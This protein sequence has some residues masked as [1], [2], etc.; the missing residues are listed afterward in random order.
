MNAPFA[1][2]L[3]GW[4]RTESKLV[5]NTADTDS[6]SSKAISAAVLDELQVPR[7]VPTGVVN[8]KSGRPLEKAVALSLR[9]DLPLHDA[10]RDWKVYEVPASISD[11]VQYSHLKKV[12]TLV[13]SNFELRITLGQDYLIKP[14]VTVA[15][16]GR[17]ADEL[18]FLHAA[19]S[20]KWTIRSDR[21]QNIRHENNQMIRHR[22]ERLPHLVTVTA[23]PQPSRLAAIAR[24]TGEVDAIYHIAF[25]ALDTAIRNL[26]LAGTIRMGQL[27]AW[28][29]CIEL[30][31]VRPFSDLAPTIARW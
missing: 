31:R 11:F 8:P 28:E 7:G 20:C 10:E 9:H 30:G 13:K 19:V 14:D 29:E 2:E 16:P 21:V 4:K 6:E 1:V 22:R 27:D 26:A 12:D 25:D 15:L 3:L 23:E 24:G 5:P 18:P 17:A